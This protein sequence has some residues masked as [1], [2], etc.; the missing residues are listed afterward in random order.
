M[1]ITREDAL[2]LFYERYPS[3][4]VDVRQVEEFLPERC[5]LLHA[6]SNCWFIIFSLGEF[7][8]FRSSNLVCVSKE[9]GQFVYEGT[10][11]DE[12]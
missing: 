9:T 12:G 2:R 1:S 8:G 10:A 4:I 7:P 3:H 5:A 11:N 6:P